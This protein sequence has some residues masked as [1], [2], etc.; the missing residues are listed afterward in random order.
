M[1]PAPEH[2]LELNAEP[3]PPVRFGVQIASWPLGAP[4]TADYY[5]ELVRHIDGLGFDLLFAGDHL[6]THNPIHEAL[7][8]L[9]YAAGAS[10][11]LTV[12]TGVLLVA[13]RNPIVTAKQLA[14][15][16]AVSGGRLIVGV[17]VG[18]EIEHEWNA[19]QIPLAERGARTDESLELMQ[20]L[21]S[22][23]VVEHH[24]EFWTVSGVT[25]SP[26]PSRPGGP[27]IWVGGRSDAALRRAARYDGWCAYAC[28]PERIRSST[29]RLAELRGD[30]DREFRTSLVLFCC[31]D[32]DESAARARTAAALG[33]RY[34][35]DFDPYID[36]FCATGTA[37]TVRQRIRDYLD[38][39]VHDLL[40]LPQVPADEMF[41]QSTR[42]AE[43]TRSL[44]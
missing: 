24:G 37:A 22:G 19:M 40:L 4:T 27:P 1:N 28:S 17:G 43:I 36:K 23:D 25:G 31:V 44:H 2:R 20:Q 14:T 39:G 9:T 21:W 41:E 42:L 29:A 15:L 10:S 8:V 3:T 11:R 5:A 18:G 38:A 6:F 35:Q 32:D 12:G 34:Q 7:T 33:K 30:D 13:L 16:D 26:A